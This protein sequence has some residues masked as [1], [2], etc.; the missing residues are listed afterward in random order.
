MSIFIAAEKI[1]MANE[2]RGLLNNFLVIS[3]ERELALRQYKTVNFAHGGQ[4]KNGG[5]LC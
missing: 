3:P 5:N 2:K 4:V 1:K